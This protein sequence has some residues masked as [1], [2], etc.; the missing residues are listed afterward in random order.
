MSTKC[1]IKWNNPGD[2]TGYHLYTDVID[3]FE[4]GDEQPIY[5][6]L[7]GVEANMYTVAGRGAVVTVTIPKK[8]ALELGLLTKPDAASGER[9]AKG[10][11]ET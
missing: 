11:A 6:E 5:L 7:V 10:S 1:S 4:H 3:S 9:S 2:T 8:I